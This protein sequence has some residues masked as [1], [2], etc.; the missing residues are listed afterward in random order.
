MKVKKMPETSTELLHTW[1]P[2]PAKLTGEEFEN[3]FLD[4]IAY[5]TTLE[6][7]IMDLEKS[8]LSFISDQD[9]KEIKKD[10]KFLYTSLK[11]Q[12]KQYR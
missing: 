7:R 1:G 4:L 11:Y 10:L 3:F 2:S 12:E 6:G 8:K 5:I 9:L